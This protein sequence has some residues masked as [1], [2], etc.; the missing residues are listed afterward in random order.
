MIAAYPD[1]IFLTDS[2]KVLNEKEEK[3]RLLTWLGAKKPFVYEITGEH[4]KHNTNEEQYKDI[5]KQF[6]Q[7]VSYDKSSNYT[8]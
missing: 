5:Q 1:R 6:K 3:K 8:S 4:K 2:Y 7:E